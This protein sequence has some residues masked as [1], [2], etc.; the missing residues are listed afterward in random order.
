MKTSE[1]FIRFVF[2]SVSECEM[3]SFLFCQKCFNTQTE[4]KG[5]T[6][7]NL[8]IR[9]NAVKKLQEVKNMKQSVYKSYDEL[10]L[11]FNAE[12]VGRVLGISSTTAYE[13]MHRKDFP[14][15]KI[16]NRLIVSKEKFIEWTNKQSERSK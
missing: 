4:R 5:L 13:L 3:R 2:V 8:H 1:Y 16:G 6:A 10:P 11:F 7:V 12:L 9:H 14:S 15:I